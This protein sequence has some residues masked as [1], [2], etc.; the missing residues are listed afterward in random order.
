MLTLISCLEK[1]TK[2]QI[3]DDLIAG[4]PS[5]SVFAKN[6][7][8]HTWRRNTNATKHIKAHR[9]ASEIPTVLLDPVLSDLYDDIVDRKY[10]PTPKDCTHALTLM[11]R[12]SHGFDEEANM[13]KFIMD[14]AEGYG[15]FL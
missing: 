11:E 15:I 13:L 9:T 14:W 7:D 4:L 8:S 10:S 2:E 6:D 12:L 3:C 5:A 1:R